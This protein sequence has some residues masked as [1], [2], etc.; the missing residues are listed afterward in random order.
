MVMPKNGLNCKDDD[1]FKIQRYTIC[2]IYKSEHNLDEMN[3]TQSSRFQLQA[4]SNVF[5][6][7]TR[8]VLMMNVYARKDMR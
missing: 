4:S 5:V 7:R 2:W 6:G 1:N 3:V 8:N